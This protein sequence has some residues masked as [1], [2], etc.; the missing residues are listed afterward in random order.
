MAK[1]GHRS[2]ACSQLDS[3]LP[4]RPIGSR[5]GASASSD[6]SK[7]TSIRRGEAPPTSHAV[8]TEVSGAVAFLCIAKEINP[9]KLIP[10][11]RAFLAV[12]PLL[13]CRSF[14]K[15]LMVEALFSDRRSYRLGTVKTA[16]TYGVCEAGFVSAGKKMMF[17]NCK[18]KVTSV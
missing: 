12:I 1:L 11:E 6:W 16:H 13:R 2:G 14:P 9:R 17:L 10:R 4:P 7:G 5:S 18:I 3:P 8:G 15:L